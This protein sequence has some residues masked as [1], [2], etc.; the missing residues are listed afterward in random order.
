MTG[1]MDATA[2]VINTQTGK[3]SDLWLG[4]PSLAPAPIPATVLSGAFH[5]RLH[6]SGENGK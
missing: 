3:V 2:K 6:L 5:V 1:S 4:I